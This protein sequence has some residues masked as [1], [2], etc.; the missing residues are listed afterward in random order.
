LIGYVVSIYRAHYLE[1]S[2]IMPNRYLSPRLKLALDVFVES[3]AYVKV[4]SIIP[5]GRVI[6]LAVIVAV[7]QVSKLRYVIN[8]KLMFSQASV[9]EPAV[10][11]WRAGLMA[12]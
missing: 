10:F 4:Y 5:T 8:A 7:T 1:S 2:I 6:E 3:L 12:L 9:N 11:E